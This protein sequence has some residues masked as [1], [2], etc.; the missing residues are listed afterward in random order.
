MAAYTS[1][2]LDKGLSVSNTWRDTL[3]A[4]TVASSIGRTYRM[5]GYDATL[6]RIVYWNAS[7]IDT[8]GTSYTGPGALSQII[9]VKIL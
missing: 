2:C 8:T 1:Q 4:A 3:D 5:R 6:A 9:L 7:V